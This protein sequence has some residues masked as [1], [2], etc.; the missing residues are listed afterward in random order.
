MEDEEGKSGSKLRITH[1]PPGCFSPLSLTHSLYLS[2]K[3]FFFI[4][5]QQKENKFIR[6]LV[7]ILV[8]NIYIFQKDWSEIKT[9]I[10]CFSWQRCS[11]KQRVKQPTGSD[12]WPTGS[13]S[14]RELQEY[15]TKES[16][17]R[18]EN[19]TGWFWKTIIRARL[20]QL[21]DVGSVSVEEEMNWEKV[22]DTSVHYQ[23]A[24]STQNGSSLAG[25]L[26]PKPCFETTV[27]ITL[28]SLYKRW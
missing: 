28:C 17:G 6:L 25:E 5:T 3:S 19:I 9:L 24:N 16:R 2:A 22:T 21:E 11:L 23:Q 10:D 20:F 13:F 12:C 8:F 7:S 26:N 1:V 4:P 14:Q 27:L 15:D 18:K